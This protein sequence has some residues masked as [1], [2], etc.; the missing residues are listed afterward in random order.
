MKPELS[1][2]TCTYHGRESERRLLN[3]LCDKSAESSQYVTIS[4]LSGSGKTSIVE[5]LPL[6]KERGAYFAAGKFDLHQSV[7]PFAAIVD[8][9]IENSA[10][11]DQKTEFS[12]A[13]YIARK[14]KEQILGT[15]H[16]NGIY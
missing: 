9:L 3:D 12:K 15:T 7:S 2:S 11:F 10:T 14:Q 13:K 4:G 6:E 1:I 8:A 16:A 5:S